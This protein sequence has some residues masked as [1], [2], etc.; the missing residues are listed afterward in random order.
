MKKVVIFSLT[1]SIIEDQKILQEK[2]AI[3]MFHVA[4]VYTYIRMEITAHVT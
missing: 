2:L 1:L 3:L 4:V